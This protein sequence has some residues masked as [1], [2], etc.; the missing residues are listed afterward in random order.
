MQLPSKNTSQ[1]TVRRISCQFPVCLMRFQANSVG[2]FCC[3][4]WKHTVAAVW[5]LP[6]FLW[7]RAPVPL[8]PDRFWKYTFVILELPPSEVAEQSQLHMVPCLVK[9]CSV[10]VLQCD[11]R[12]LA[13]A[14]R[15]EVPLVLLEA[16]V[17]WLPWVGLAAFCI[18]EIGFLFGIRLLACCPSSVVRK[19]GFRSY[20]SFDMLL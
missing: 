1:P 10:A 8:L 11:Q 13:Q 4:I 5:D 9:S 20:T 19:S 3:C 7:K 15:C 16:R 2:F 12:G 18:K 17:L 6:F 14:A